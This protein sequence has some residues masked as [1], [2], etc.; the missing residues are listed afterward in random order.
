ME[1]SNL[2]PTLQDSLVL[3][4]AVERVTIQRVRMVWIRSEFCA[5]LS[6]TL[7]TKILPTQLP[8]AVL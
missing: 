8:L 1:E 2:V 4:D 3:Q 5:C 7:T 6:L